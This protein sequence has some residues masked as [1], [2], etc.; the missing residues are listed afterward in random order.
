MEST[1]DKGEVLF[2]EMGRSMKMDPSQ[3]V[4]LLKFSRKARL[5]N[6]LS[7]CRV[8][9]QVILHRCDDP[10]KGGKVL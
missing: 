3:L 1:L 5:R 2:V 6:F 4:K 9:Q 10:A 7:S 8:R